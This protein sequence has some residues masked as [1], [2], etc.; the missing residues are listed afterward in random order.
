MQV[1]LN[2]DTMVDLVADMVPESLKERVR[3][4][5]REHVNEIIES[6]RRGGK[7]KL[8]VI[9][10][11]DMTLSRFKCDGRRCPTS[12][13][14][15]ENSH[16]V[17]ETCRNKL[18]ELFNTYCPLEKDTKK[19][20]E[21]KYSLMVKW[22]ECNSFFK[23]LYSNEVPLFIFSAGIGDVLE[24]VLRQA[25][26]L[27]KNVTV[28]ANYMDFDEKG[29]LMGF[30][31]ELIHTYNKNSSV[32]ADTKY[33]QQQSERTNILL[34]GDSLGDPTMADGVTRVDSILKIGFLNDKVEENREAYLEAYDIVLEEV[35][36]MEVVNRI[37][38]FVYAR[39]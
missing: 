4:K 15:I 31:G 33:F 20:T 22:D 10:D 34:L 38:C 3:M 23:G 5:N 27:D 17:S 12:Y 28:V 18:Q 7:E 24:E 37:L 39:N 16:L 1:P 6:L 30:K 9:S 19:T 35:E 8:Q 29:L 2:A 14:I 32:L 36:T 11:F 13:N 25:D 21:E 26:V